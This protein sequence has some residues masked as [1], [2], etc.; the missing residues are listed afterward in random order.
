MS[1]TA[2]KTNNLFKMYNKIRLCGNNYG[3][4]LEEE[5]Q[6]LTSC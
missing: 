5:L 6:P 2:L 4:I 1:L 3:T